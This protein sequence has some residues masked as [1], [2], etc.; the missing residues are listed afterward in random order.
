MELEKSMNKFLPLLLAGLVAGSLSMGVFAEDAVKSSA[1]KVTSKTIAI[2]RAN[3]VK[4]VAI[5]P[6]AASASKPAEVKKETRLKDKL[7]DLL[8]H[9]K[10]AAKP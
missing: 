7:K 1:T 3:S 6:A 4:P 8:P 2:K 10:D 9:A 5:S